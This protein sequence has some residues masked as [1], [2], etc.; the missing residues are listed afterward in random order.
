MPPTIASTSIGRPASRSTSIDGLKTDFGFSLSITLSAME[1]DNSATDSEGTHALAT[2]RTS[3]MIVLSAA[4]DC[5]TASTSQTLQRANVHK[6]EKEEFLDRV[7][8]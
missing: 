4:R 5:G 2:V 1:S 7:S 6:V 3:N 8:A